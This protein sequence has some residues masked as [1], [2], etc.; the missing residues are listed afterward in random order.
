[1]SNQQ[2]QWHNALSTRASLEAALAEVVE[3]LSPHFSQTP[4]LAIL[5]ISSA[6]ASEYPRVIPLLL[7][8]WPLPIVI[9]CGGGGIIGISQNQALEIESNPAVSL[10][11]AS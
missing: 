2:F 9:G 7:E 6:Y 10:S 4:D 1:M 8:K 3:C 5:F 11:V